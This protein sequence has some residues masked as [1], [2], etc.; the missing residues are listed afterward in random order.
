MILQDYDLI[1]VLI[2]NY[3]NIANTI[4]DLTSDIE[5]LEDDITKIETQIAN[6]T[7]DKTWAE[8]EIVLIQAQLTSIVTQITDQTDVVAYW[9]A[10]LDAEIAAK[11]GN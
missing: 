10:L 7:I 4:D 5:N 1:D 11:S 3:N 2:N 9:K 8:G 6:N